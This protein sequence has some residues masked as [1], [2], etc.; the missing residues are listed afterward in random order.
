MIKEHSLRILFA[1]DL[2]SDAELAVMELRKG[3]LEFE[4]MVVDSR[5]DFLAA[6]KDFKPDIVISDYMMPSFNGLQ[7]LKDSRDYDPFMPF[8]LFTGSTNEEI[9]VEC[10]KAG[11]SDYVIKEHMTRLPFAVTEVIEQARVHK[12]KLEYNHLLEVSHRSLNTLISRLPGIVYRCRND[13]AR[14]MEF[15]SDVAG[16]MTG[17]K[18]GELILNKKKSYFDI[19]YKDDRETV[20][21]EID[22]AI[23]WKKSYLLKYRILRK[24]KKIIWVWDNGE[25]VFN[26]NGEL[27]FLEG[28]ITDITSQKLAEDS[29]KES[30][31]LFETLAQAAPVGIFRTRPDGYTTYVNPRWTELAGIKAEDAL[32]N[33]W[34][35]AVHPDDRHI[36][37]GKWESDVVQKKPSYAEYRFLRPDGTVCWVIGNAVPEYSGGKIFGYI[38]TITDITE[39]H[40]ADIELHKLS[41]AVEQSPVS[42]AITDTDGTIEYVN[43][44][45]CAV[46]GYSQKELIG[47]NPRVLSTMEKSKDD[48]KLMWDTIKSGKDWQ[49]EFHNK[50]K[51]GD[52]YWESAT[53]S[54]IRNDKNE[55]THF[56]GIK[57]DISEKKRSDQV[58]KAL[59]EISS[60]VVTNTELEDLLEIIQVQV[61][62]ILDSRNFFLAFYDEPT[63]SLYSPMA[64]DE[65][66]NF[67]TWTA[68]K[69]LTWHVMKNNRSVI[70]K[71]N[72]IIELID[73]G[74]IELVGTI[75]E[76]WIG[77]P[78]HISDRNLG[79]FVLQSYDNQDA[80]DDRDVNMLEFIANQ[81]SQSIQRRDA[82][83]E[84]RE[85]LRKAEAGDRLKTTF[86]NNISH[87]VRTPLNGILGF[88]ELISKPGLPEKER[89]DLLA[90]LSESSDRLLNT[91]TNYMDI[92]L[93]T[94]ETLTVHK[95]DFFPYHIL[96]DMYG[97][98]K[99]ICDKRNLFLILDIPVQTEEISLHSDP[100]IFRKIM[101]H[102]LDNAVKFT[103]QGNISY[104]FCLKN[105]TMEFF[106]QDTGIGINP[107]SAENIFER[108]MKEDRGMVNNTEGSGLGLSIAK[109]MSMLLGGNIRMDSETGKGS[110]FYLSL[111]LNDAGSL[112]NAVKKTVK[113]YGS[114]V[115][116]AED[117]ETNFFYIN[118]LLKHETGFTVLHAIN[119]REAIE[120]YR[121]N[122]DIALVLMDIKM[123]DMDGIEATKMIKQINRDVPVIAVTAYA[124]LGDEEKIL[125]AGCD[126]YLSKPISKSSLLR[127][128]SKFIRI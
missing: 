40:L 73:S 25:G 113:G 72:E 76:C 47:N 96:K 63:G 39:R 49:G 70:L 82:I 9:A 69:S 18:S 86:L 103:E 125:A 56:L 115:L 11:A 119:G 88:S 100:E 57:E 75:A 60:A 101:S 77:V 61:G 1:E 74:E 19:I 20:R 17:Y 84:L 97:K 78:L 94:S 89:R 102:F 51:N 46:T 2:P 93:L 34:L 65:K 7:A 64:K 43:P 117:D 66:D 67:V 55:I 37:S 24:D 21:G 27:Q 80:Y 41:R 36:V 123:S 58:Q 26:D 85:A 22:E 118:A 28:F 104:G 35:K 116:V 126:G 111:P 45:M 91:I 62:T 50:K 52:L 105:E 29:L 4:H 3:G 122:P 90:M 5:N 98:Y 128:I 127:A 44:K 95:K 81:I 108:F 87:E 121:N 31:Q 110:T 68:E 109:G 14:T 48:Y 6:L 13:E 59:F 54:P 8:I 16:E 38:G 99:T 33:G 114:K 32:G 83:T 15:I 106:V 112:L 71:K 23:K 120:L 53:I 10:M 12:E 42:I 79:A 107:E 92:S 30:R 124:M